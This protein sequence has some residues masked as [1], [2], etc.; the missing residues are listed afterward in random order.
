MRVVL[1]FRGELG[2]KLRYHVPAVHAMRPDVVCMEPDEEALYPSAGTRYLVE[3]NRDDD[4]REKYAKD[5]AYLRTLEPQLR[6]AFP[7]AQFV[8]TAPGMPEARFIPEPLL[9]R[10]L[11][12]DVVICPRKRVY[13]ASKNWDGWALLAEQLQAAGLSV[14]AGGAPDSS[15]PVPC[16][17]AWELERFLD[18]T[19]EAMLVAR[20][21]VATDAGLAHLAV[22]CGRPLVLIAY[23]GGLV[24]PGPVLDSDG[25]QTMP[26][27]WPIRLDRYYHQANH[28]HAPIRVVPNG[29]ERPEDVL[30]AAL[31]IAR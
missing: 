28:M 16:P 5:G 15:N 31:E 8:E 26:I 9:R 21:V 29:W 19:I 24:A 7:R 14:F 25:H 17:A 13:G 10:G 1:P 27:Y 23:G 3:R 11:A 4:R 2:L 18:A 22:L 6:A 20:V 12:A 30:A